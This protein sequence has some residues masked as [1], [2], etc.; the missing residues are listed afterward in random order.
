[1]R[2]RI[3][4]RTE[5]GVVRGPQ[6]NGKPGPFAEPQLEKELAEIRREVVESRNLVIKTDNLLKNLH[7]ELKTV[8]KRQEDIFKR[9][10]AGS[11]IAYG[12]IG[13]LAF[14]GSMMVANARVSGARDE[15]GGLTKQTEELK[16]QLAALQTEVAQRKS[17]ADAASKVYNAIADGQTEQ[18]RLKAVDQ[19]A[20]LDRTKLNPLE[21][22]A[23]EDRAR[24]LKAELANAALEEGRTAYRRNE[25]KT[26]AVGLRRF[27][28]LAPDSSEVTQAS[29]MLGNALHEV[30]DYPGSVAPLEK[31]LQNPKGQK[32]VDYAMLMLAQAYENVGDHAKTMTVMD[33]ATR[34]YPGSRFIQDMQ[35][36]YSRAKKSNEQAATA[37]A[38]PTPAPAKN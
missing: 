14:V 6:T 37:A 27:L 36:L 11:A 8:S 18:A 20:A 23:L 24:F 38:G 16:G 9:G 5:E 13:I 4:G 12:A 33:K 34:E 29:F 30:K 35:H 19:L 26:A 22:R 2:S 15:V 28:T 3:E 25:F 1:M 10:W 31:F 21:A 7:A 32:D 17:T